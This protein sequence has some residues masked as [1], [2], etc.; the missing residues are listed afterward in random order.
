MSP[1]TPIL[2]AAGCSRRMGR[3]KA[4][5]ELAGETCLERALRACREGGAAAPVVVVGHDA[6]AVRAAMP[7]GV[8]SVLNPDYASTGPAASLQRGL[9]RLPVEAGAFLLYP[10]DFPLVTGREVGALLRRWEEVR[11]RGRRIVVPSHDMRRG[12]PALFAR[13]L[14]RKFQALEPDAP[15]H[16]VLRAHEEEVEHLVVENPGILMNMDTPEDYRRC[17]EALEGPAP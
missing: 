9:E 6:E 17:R 4:L 11:A 5:L 2:L 10:V 8:A 12:H 15:L 14:V 13:S 3:T 16:R 7:A 1:V